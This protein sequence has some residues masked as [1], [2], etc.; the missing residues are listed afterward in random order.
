MKYLS[1]CSGV[2]A[3][4]S[5]QKLLYEALIEMCINLIQKVKNGLS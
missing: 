5:N 3:V 4:L 2:E 1:V